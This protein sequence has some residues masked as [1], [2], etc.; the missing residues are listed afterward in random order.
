MRLCPP[1]TACRRS[2][3]R[4][5]VGAPLHR[6]L[7]ASWPSSWPGSAARSS[8]TPSPTCRATAPTASWKG[9]G[10]VL[11]GVSGAVGVAVVA[12]LALRAMGEW[13]IIEL[14]GDPGPGPHQAPPAPVATA[15]RPTAAGRRP[16]W[17]SGGR[18]A[19]ASE[20]LDRAAPRSIAT[21]STGTDMVTEMDPGPSTLI[22]GVCSPPGPTTACWARRAPTRP[23]RRGRAGSSIPSTA[24]PTTCTATRAFASRSRPR[25]TAR[26]SPGWWSTRPR[27]HL[28]RAARGGGATRN[29]EPITLLGRSTDLR[30]A[31]VATGFGYDRRPA[32]PPGRRCSRRSSPRSAT[33]AGWARPPSTC[34]RSP[35]GGSTP[36]T[37]WASPLGLRRRR[38][39][40]RRGR[41]DLVTDLDGGPDRRA[42]ALA[43]QPAPA[44]RRCGRPATAARRRRV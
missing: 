20:S 40:R 24:R 13:R 1:P 17:P 26:S 28:H 19:A 4:G 5:G 37:S 14:T 31:L 33:S 15:P 11:G 18:P 25:S 36:T 30:R 21:K 43:A 2:P 42:F 44:R 34:A 16:T 38:A 6:P 12:V 10:L 29:G 41:G 8:A 7:V 3:A 22:V 9:L 32:P 27:R 39:H 35:A 23:A